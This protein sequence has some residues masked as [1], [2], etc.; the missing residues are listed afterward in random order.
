MDM[1]I[2]ERKALHQAVMET[3]E[4]IL[5]SDLF[6]NAAQ[7]SKEDYH[8]LVSHNISIMSDS[9]AGRYERNSQ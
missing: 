9:I 1:N 2:E 5:N 4:E 8:F 7:R 3:M 6:T